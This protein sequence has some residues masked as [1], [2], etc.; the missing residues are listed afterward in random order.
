[1]GTREWM[2]ALAA[3]V[4]GMG[5]TFVLAPEPGTELER[6]WKEELELEIDTIEHTIGGT[7]VELPFDAIGFTVRRAFELEDELEAVAGGRA[8]SLVRAFG[9]SEL[10]FGLALDGE[11]VGELEGQHGCDGTELRFRW[12]EEE[13]VYARERIAGELDDEALARLEPDLDLT[14]LLPEGE[15][16]PGA[17]FEPPLEALRAFFR[18]GGDLGW[19]PEHIRLTRSDVPP[20][21]LIAG[22]LGTLSEL[23]TPEAE[24]TGRLEGR[25]EGTD[26]DEGTARLVYALDLELAADLG[27]R[28]R[29]YMKEAT[30]VS[31]ALEL[32]AEL[33]GELVLLWDVAGRR[34]RSARFEGEVA[35]EG[36]LTFPLHGV[37]GGVP[38]PFVG[39]YELSGTV[40]VELTSE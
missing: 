32:T 24:L 16:D 4:M 28:F 35:M 12:D 26:E 22:A 1:M 13:E 27:E 31:H 40:V 23:F 34:P 38:Q 39:E 30:E 33:E 5:E 7:P 11:A 15:L 18:A 9:S 17:T 2:A 19:H 10:G 20:E 29:A 3:L 21:L 6:R 36:E 8:T 14:A 37:E 25:F